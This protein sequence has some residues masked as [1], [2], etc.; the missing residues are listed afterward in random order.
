M[1]SGMGVQCVCVCQLCERW[2]AMHLR[3]CVQWSKAKQHLVPPESALPC[4]HTPQTPTRSTADGHAAKWR[5]SVWGPHGQTHA[6]NKKKERKNENGKRQG[7]LFKWTPKTAS[8]FFHTFSYFSHISPP[9]LLLYE[10][11]C[12]LSRGLAW[13]QSVRTFWRLAR[14][15]AGDFTLLLP[16]TMHLQQSTTPVQKQTKKTP[17]R[18]VRV[19]VG[20]WNL[21]SPTPRWKTA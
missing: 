5:E 4:I 7:K 10:W 12:A 6:V 17:H 11:G 9:S 13:S 18:D 1:H 3:P 16:V 14:V 15:C 2:C 19:C 8:P 20:G 21:K